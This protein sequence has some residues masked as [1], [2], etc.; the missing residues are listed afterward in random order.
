MNRL[1]D[2][3]HGY[4]IESLNRRIRIAIDND[5]QEANRIE[6]V[7]EIPNPDNPFNLKKYPP[8]EIPTKILNRMPKPNIITK[9]DSFGKGVG[10]VKPG[11][12]GK[13]NKGIKDDLDQTLLGTTEDDEL[14]IGS[15]GTLYAAGKGAGI[16]G[17]LAGGALANLLTKGIP[18]S[19][20]GGLRPTSAKDFLKGNL[21]MFGADVLSSLGK[22]AKTLS[23]ADY[24]DA[25]MGDIA[26]QQ[27]KNQISGAG[28]PFAQLRVPYDYRRSWTGYYSAPDP[29]LASGTP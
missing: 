10:G 3:A 11:D 2:Q 29:G 28:R 26:Y 14:G 6:D 1:P 20:G 25:N 7:V 21:G 18:Q 5:I 12:Y 4:L 16:L 23:G 24:F 27:L 8:I 15:A 17:D 9:K 19:R 22:Q 13:P